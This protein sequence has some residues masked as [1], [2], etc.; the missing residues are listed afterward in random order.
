M[1]RTIRTQ[2]RDILLDDEHNVDDL[3]SLIFEARTEGRVF[4]LEF[5]DRLA[6]ALLDECDLANHTNS[7]IEFIFHGEE[8]EFGS[9]PGWTIRLHKNINVVGE[10]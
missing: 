5:N 10:W 2:T 6:L 7:C 1:S 3:S 9:T 4:H 8:D